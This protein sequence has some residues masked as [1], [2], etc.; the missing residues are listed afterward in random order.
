MTANPDRK[1]LVRLRMQR[2]GESYT[3]AL[4]NLRPGRK[5]MPSE[6]VIT[7]TPVGRQTNLRV[8]AMTRKTLTD[9]PV[10]RVRGVWERS[11]PIGPALSEIDAA[12]EAQDLNLAGPPYWLCGHLD[13]EDTSG[14]IPWE[15]GVPVDRVGVDVGRVEA[16]VL[17]GG[18]VASIFY[19]GSFERSA[20]VEAYLRGQIEAAGLVAVGRVRWIGLTDPA[21]VS[22]PEEHY[23]ELVWPVTT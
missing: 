2:T 14:P 9:Q 5:A 11:N 7:K 21:R 3:A 6:P 8:T 4:R 19:D 17:P 16:T 15:A 10:L 1:R 22:D 18:E 12:I 23:S 13:E 20:A